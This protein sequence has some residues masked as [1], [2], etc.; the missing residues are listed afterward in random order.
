MADIIDIIGVN[1]SNYTYK[2]TVDT[3]PLKYSGDVYIKSIS[4]PDYHY[5][6]YMKIDNYYS[7]TFFVEGVDDNIYIN[8]TTIRGYQQYQFD[9]T[10]S[11]YT[12]N[13]YYTFVDIPIAIYKLTASNGN[14]FKMIDFNQTMVRGS[15]SGTLSIIECDGEFNSYYV[16]CFRNKDSFLIGEYPVENN[17][18]IIPNLDCNTDYDIVLVDQSRTLEQKILSFR[19]PTPY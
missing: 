14:W 12:I 2:Y 10:T 15:L 1:S 17:N 8:L 7:P 18:Y 3:S 13:G 4:K 19:K 6:Y 11:Q 16:K 9:T 5:S